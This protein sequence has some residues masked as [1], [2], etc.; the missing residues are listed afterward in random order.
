MRSGNL[1]RS[2]DQSRSQEVV[3]QA[4]CQQPKDG[5]VEAAVFEN[6]VH[7]THTGAEHE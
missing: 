4:P 6:Q 5:M 7:C 1:K 2:D 3:A